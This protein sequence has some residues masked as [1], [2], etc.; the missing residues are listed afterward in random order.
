MIK[1]KE[2]KE[3]PIAMNEEMQPPFK[4]KTWEL[5]PPKGVKPVGCKWVFKKKEGIRG[6]N[7]LDSR[8]GL[9]HKDSHKRRELIIMKYL[10]HL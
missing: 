10:L 6:L 9:W 8:H 7:L 2:A 5:V 1:S 4:N 3:W